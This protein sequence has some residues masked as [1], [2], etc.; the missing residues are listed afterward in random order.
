MGIKHYWSWFRMKF[1]NN[2]SELKRGDVFQDKNISIDNLMIDMNGLFHT[3]AQ[4]VYEYG[5]FKKNRQLLSTKPVN[6]NSFQQQLKMFKDVCETV[7][8]VLN[9]VVPKK[10]LILCVD[11]PAPLSKQNQQRKRR[12]MSAQTNN[13]EFDSNCITPGTKFT[14]HL[15][16]YIDWYIKKKISENDILWSNIEVIF[17]NEKAPGEGEHKLF[18]FLRK[19]GDIEES[20]CIHG[21]DADLIML[22]LG[23]HVSKFFILREEPM[24]SSVEFYVID[25]GNTRKDMCDLMRWNSQKKTFNE[26]TAINDFIFMCFTV[27]NDFL[28]HIPGLE[29]IEGAIDFMLD[30]YK[31]T[32]S[33]YGHLTMKTKDGFKFRRRAF[34]AFLGTVSQYEKGVLEEKLMHKDR[35]F[36]DIIL[37]TSSKIVDGKYELDIEKYHTQYYIKNLP[38]IEN[39]EEFCHYYLDGM[40]MVLSYYLEGKTNWTW[41]YMYHYAP[42]AN[43]IATHILSYNFKEEKQTT[44]SVP[45]VQLLCVLPPKS[46]S[47]L[48]TPLDS[49]LSSEIS[50]LAAFCPTNFQ[51]DLSGK[52]QNWEGIVLLPVVDYQKVEKCYYDSIKKVDQKELKRNIL[53]KSFIYSKTNQSY[54]FNSFYGNFTCNVFT[55]IIDI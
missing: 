17:S 48:P 20:Y 2:I 27:G 30:V 41:K 26:S 23:T 52:R 33:E 11:G 1:K 37:E 54:I 8:K 53:G 32:C 24:K 40:Q 4:K 13:I 16:K 31:N 55:K 28:P 51:V 49:L 19:Y 46:A 34:S 36:Q 44:P 39:K 35:F 45:F 38:E 21:M 42:F 3:S 18:N 12:F 50:P 43:E 29:I 22:S 10:R 5:N 15:T 6:V 7:D 14:D 9:I 47:L 25:I